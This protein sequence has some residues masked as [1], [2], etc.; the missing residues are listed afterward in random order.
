MHVA[1]PAEPSPRTF[2]RSCEFVRWRITAAGLNGYL[3]AITA[4]SISTF[5]AL[6]A[7]S[8]APV[9]AA[10]ELSR[11]YA[12]GPMLAK[13]LDGP[14]KGCE[15][16]IFAERVSMNDHW[17]VNFGYYSNEPERRGY[18]EGGRLLRMN[19]RTGEIKVLLDDPKGGVRDPQVH[20]D[21]QKILMSYR[22][23]GTETYLLYEINADGSGLKQLT[24]GTDDDIEPAYLPDG[25]IVFSSA[26]CRRFVNCWYSRVTTL[27]RCDGDGSNIRMLSSNNDHDNTP[28]VLPDGRILYMRWEYVD[29]SQVHYHHLW[30]MNPDGTGQMVYFGNEIGGIVMIDAKPIPGTNKVVA[31]FS[32]GHGIPEHIGSVAIVDPR[33]GPDVPGAARNV[34]KKGQHFRDPWAYSEECFL[35][36]ANN[37]I[38]VMDGQGN[39]EVVY[40]TPETHKYLECHEPRPLAPRPCEAVI[41]SRV[42]L[43][44]PT[45]RLVLQ[46]MYAGRKVDGIQ[47]GE[48]KKLLILQQVPKPVNFS[49]GMEPLTLGG[50]FTLAQIVGTVPVE[51]DG[52]VYM[53]VPALKSLFFV[54]LD[55]N[56]MAV[57]RMQSFCI[58]QP[59]ETISCVGCHEHRGQAPHFKPDLAALRRPPSV[60]EPIADVPD[61]FDFPRDIQPILDRHCVSCHNPDR[62]EGHV[63]LCG[64][65]T[66][67]YTISYET[68]VRRQLVAD[69]RNLPL[70]NRPPRSI[71]SSASKLLKMVDGSHYG[72]QVSPH[73]FKMLRLWIETSATYPG[74]YAALGCGMYYVHTPLQVMLERCGE[75]HSTDAKNKKNDPLR[76]AFGGRPV[77]HPSM[78]YNL[79]RPEKSMVLMFPLSKEAG[80]LGLCRDVP[81]KSADDP[82]YQQILTAVRKAS[83][84]LQTHK[85]FDMPGFRP[86]E[87]Y[88]REMQRFG[89]LPRDLKPTDAIDVYATDRAYWRSFDYQPQADRA[90][91]IGGP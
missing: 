31:S 8:A 90:G 64:D 89:I 77:N 67:F 11:T 18:G 29:R 42:D 70:G 28:W 6:S 53:E 9:F 62:F 82:A 5:A 49:G 22:K 52:S 59:G 45:G 27:Y 87:H 37:K 43:S 32:P 46:D 58:V 20:Y 80:G 79:S 19:L 41:P 47:P 30:T 85:R 4:V 17:Y 88:I 50:S 71:G 74:T 69:G 75:C 72:V 3:K 15:E 7:L 48:V 63:D 10:E 76:L 2:V 60:V 24:H 57:K 36:A 14:M 25:G 66:P 13:F 56:D 54:A 23:G 12:P 61:V 26:R 55:E 68:I 65:K 86:N 39:T 21:G 51:A 83:A 1:N 34:S 91:D 84:E 73:E 40:Q 81:F 35:V 44:K 78:L 16:I 33:K 38:L